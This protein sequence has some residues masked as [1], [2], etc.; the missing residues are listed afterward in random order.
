MTEQNSAFEI[1]LGQDVPIIPKTEP[2]TEGDIM[3]DIDPQPT[4]KQENEG[5]ATNI[6]TVNSN[7]GTNTSQMQDDLNVVSNL[8]TSALH[9][10]GVDNLSTEQVRKY[11]KTHGNVRRFQLEWVNDT[12]VNVNLFTPQAALQVIMLLAVAPPVHAPQVPIPD[13]VLPH[14][15]VKNQDKF[16]SFPS[17]Q[18]GDVSGDGIIGRGVA[19]GGNAN[20]QQQT[21][22]LEDLEDM[23][24]SASAVQALVDVQYDVEAAIKNG[25]LTGAE[26]FFLTERRAVPINFNNLNNNNGGNNGDNGDGMNDDSD[27]P[28][29]YVRYALKSDVKVHGARAQSRYYLLHGEPTLEDDLISYGD[30]RKY[31]RD[32]RLK[33]SGEDSHSKNGNDVDGDQS[34]DVEDILSSKV[35]RRIE[36]K[37]YR[38]NRDA[39]GAKINRGD[40]EQDGE[41]DIGT[42]I[43]D[44][45]GTGVTRVGNN[46]SFGNMHRNTSLFDRIGVQSRKNGQDNR[47]GEDREADF[48]EI[49]NQGSDTRDRKGSSEFGSGRQNRHNRQRSRSRSPERSSRGFDDD[50]TND[51]RY[52]RGRR[53]DRDR[54]SRYRN[55]NYRDRRDDNRGRR[56]EREYGRHGRSNDR[57]RD[58][59]GDSSYV[60]GDN[61]RQSPKTEDGRWV[62][63][64]L[65]EEQTWNPR[66]SSHRESKGTK[67]EGYQSFADRL[68]F[69]KNQ[70]GNDSYG[71]RRRNKATDHY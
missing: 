2:D 51:D 37:S 63:G 35:L 44:E 59:D 4:V 41:D 61:N 18:G 68:S 6:N 52:G 17:A 71:K 57:R 1:D 23:R 67:S 16:A 29:L 64:D 32:E 14:L 27:T 66:Q 46:V 56:S 30:I 24:Q 12:S 40:N 25:S 20:S 55:S 13:P 42:G 22:A 26:K 15:V 8:R 62:R 58:W 9:L 50:E 31:D 21:L 48:G 60:D 53:D 49:L 7:S 38:R 28:P 43:R 54:R 65:L 39:L 3:M 10:T 19:S 69:G 34:N 5:D 33:N 47:S 36:S 45:Y 11:V 70:D